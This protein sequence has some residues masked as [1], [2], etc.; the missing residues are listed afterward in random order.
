MAINSNV[1]STLIYT[2]LT[3]P[4]LALANQGFS[5]NKHNIYSTQVDLGG[6]CINK[7]PH[8]AGFIRGFVP[9][10][11]QPQ[12]VTFADL[13]YL[14]TNS[15]G[16]WGG[17]IGIG[18]RQ[19]FNNEQQMLGG[20]FYIDRI[21][22]INNTFFSKI[23]PGVEYW[24]KNHYF[25]ANFYL[26]IGS[27][28]IL[29]GSS[30]S[31]SLG[32][33]SLGNIVYIQTNQNVYDVSMVGGDIEYGY[34][35]NYNSTSYLGAFYY[36]SSTSNVPTP[37][38][39]GAFVKTRYSIFPRKFLNEASIDAQ[40]QY[41]KLRNWIAYISVRFTFAGNRC[42]LSQM[43]Q[44]MVDPIIRTLDLIELNQDVTTITETIVIPN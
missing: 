4:G 30:S 7:S 17:N 35:F 39:Q 21:R 41:D 20:H 42:K 29:D 43:Q 40:I 44:H 9:I 37:I 24:F 11:Q 27:K 12:Q 36:H 18:L 33:D 3:I 6:Y 32:F 10:A 25:G 16:S 28:S 15:N 26:P 19:M 31:S 14:K 38:V 5:H 34:Q 22:T 2:L 1:F 23:S 8:R 13:R